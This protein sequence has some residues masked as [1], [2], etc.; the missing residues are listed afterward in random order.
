MMV[1]ARTHFVC[2]YCMCLFSCSHPCNVQSLNMY[3]T[4]LFLAFQLPNGLGQ[5]LETGEG[6]TAHHGESTLANP[7]THL[8]K[9]FGEFC[10]L[11]VPRK[12]PHM[13]ADSITYR[14]SIEFAAPALGIG[15]YP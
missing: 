9:R 12:V 5:S 6:Y 2:E 11:S 8:Q 1:R 3:S 14:V 13:Y 10:S 4:C 7:Q 15:S